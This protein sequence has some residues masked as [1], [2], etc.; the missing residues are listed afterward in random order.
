MRHRKTG[1]KLGMDSSARKAMW[2]NMVTSLMLHGQIRTTE[3]RAKE[4]RRF[5]DRVITI[6]K[7]A[8]SIVSF[9]GL[10]DDELRQA[11][12]NRV[13]AI[14]RAKQWVN[15]DEA[16]D[17]VFTE[18]AERFRTRPGGYTR[19]VKA[20]RRGGD[21]ASM[22]IIELVEALAPAAP[23]AAPEADPAPAE[24]EPEAAEVVA[25][26][27]P[28]A[29]PEAAEVPEQDATDFDDEPT[30]VQVVDDEDT[31]VKAAEIAEE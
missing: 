31:V 28:E 19:I 21:N 18:Y 10:A 22:A 7:R 9:E 16:L 15:N 20:G 27:E 23:D 13:A 14:R 2:R 17:L 1:R 30:V 26:P 6:G 5:A 29:A 25:A 11:R 24:A 12:A 4:L 8:P 3:Q